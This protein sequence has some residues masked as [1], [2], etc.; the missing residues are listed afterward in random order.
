MK[1]PGSGRKSGTPNKKT[2]A[3]LEKAEALGVDPFEFLCLTLKGDWKAIGLQAKQRVLANGNMESID[4]EISFADRYSAARELCQYLYPKRSSVK[5]SAEEE[6]GFK[7]I[8]E[9]WTEKKK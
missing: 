3:L 2:Q 9:D 7:I 1:T 5:I 6:A 4:P 8:I